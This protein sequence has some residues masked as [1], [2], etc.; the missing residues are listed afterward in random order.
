VRTGV[1]DDTCKSFKPA[2]WLGVLGLAILFVLLR[3]NNFNAPLIRDEG[4]Y[5]YAAQLLLNSKL[6]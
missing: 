3:W 1:R 2:L 6:P 4:E 5:A